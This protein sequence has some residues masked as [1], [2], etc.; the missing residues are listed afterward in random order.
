MSERNPTGNE[1]H[2]TVADSYPAIAASVNYNRARHGLPL[3]QLHEAT[4]NPAE[5]AK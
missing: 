5:A 4:G 3:V 1:Q 2:S